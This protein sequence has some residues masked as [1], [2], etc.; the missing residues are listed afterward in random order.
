MI[1]IVVIVFV[2]VAIAALVFLGFVIYGLIDES[3]NACVKARIEAESAKKEA[4]FWKSK[5]RV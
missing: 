4:E 2:V 1:K 5:N 3:L